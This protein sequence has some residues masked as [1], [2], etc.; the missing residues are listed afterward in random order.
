MEEVLVTNKSSNEKTS[1]PSQ[2]KDSFIK[3][4]CIGTNDSMLQFELKLSSYSELPMSLSSTVNEG[5]GSLVSS[6]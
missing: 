5:V 4:Q 6:I 3:M 2:K 1:T